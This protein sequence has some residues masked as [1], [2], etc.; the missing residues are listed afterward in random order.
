MIFTI[1]KQQLLTV[2]APF[3]GR[4]LEVAVLSSGAGG[5]K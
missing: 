3:P 4:A 2:G 1:K 5:G